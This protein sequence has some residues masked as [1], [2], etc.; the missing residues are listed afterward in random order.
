MNTTTPRRHE[1]PRCALAL[2]AAS[3]VLCATRVAS[4]EPEGQKIFGTVCAACH[5]LGEGPKV[6]PD[7]KDVTVRRD[8]AWLTRFI[9][10]PASV[11][12]SGDPIAKANVDKYKTQMP[13]LGLTRKDVDAVVAFLGQ[14][15]AATVAGT[16][17]QYLP[18][19]GIGAA[20]LAALTA[21]GLV[22]GNKKVEVGP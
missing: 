10:D 22:A 13:N 16:P 11:R 12:A 18:S 20:L 17:P 6:G 19:L 15:S 8:A 4:A 21:I 3:M 7:L 1:N 2:L 14:G 5:T 9:S